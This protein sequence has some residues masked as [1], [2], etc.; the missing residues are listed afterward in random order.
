ME[1]VGAESAP[2]DFGTSGDDMPEWKDIDSTLGV[3]KPWSMVDVPDLFLTNL[4]HDVD[5]TFTDDSL[6]DFSSTMNN[7]GSETESNS[8]AF[9]D[10]MM[11]Q[12]SPESL[13]NTPPLVQHGSEGGVDSAMTSPP[14]FPMDGQDMTPLTNQQ[15]ASIFGFSP[16][17]SWNQEP[18]QGISPTSV[19]QSPPMPVHKPVIPIR[20]TSSLPD[21][22]LS[23]SQVPSGTPT[24]ESILAPLHMQ[25]GSN[26]NA[27]TALNRLRAVTHEC[28]KK[29]QA[30]K[31]RQVKSSSPATTPQA[32]TSS[33]MPADASDMWTRKNAHNAIER[34]YRSNINDRIAGL[35]DVVPALREMQSRGPRRKRRRG[36]AEEVELVDGI[37]AATKLSK[38]TILSKATEYIC[39]L[40]S[41]EVRLSREVA[42]LHMLLRSLEGGDE[43][44]SQWNAEMERLHA[45]YPP[46]DAVYPDGPTVPLSPSEDAE[47]GDLVDESD[48]ADDSESVSSGGEPMR[49]KA[50]RYMLG[51]FLIPSLLGRAD[52]GTEAPGVV[53]QTHVM[54]VCHQLWKRSLGSSDAAHPYDHIPFYDLVWEFLRGCTLLGLVVVVLL[55][56][57]AHIRQWSRRLSLKQSSRLQFVA[58]AEALLRTPAEQAQAAE[59]V[60]RGHAKRMYAQLGELLHVPRTYMALTWGTAYACLCLLATVIPGVTAWIRYASVDPTVS[61]LHRRAHMR[62]AELEVTLGGDIQPDLAQRL[63]TLVMVQYAAR[64]YGAALDETLLLAL[65]YCDL[66]QHTRLPFLMRHGAYLWRTTGA[67]LVDAPNSDEASQR[68][69]AE[70]LSV[71][72]PQALDYARTTTTE[73]SVIISPLANMLEALRHEALLSYWT[74]MI[75]SMMR[76]AS[77]AEKQWSPNVLDVIKDSASLK[78]IQQQLRTLSRDGASSAAFTEQMLVAHGMLD[79]AAGRLT[80]AQMHAR[81]LKQHQP[82]S[83]AAQQFLALWKDTPLV[84]GVPNGPVDMLASVVIGWFVL[85]RKQHLHGDKQEVSD[86]VAVC[87]STLQALASQCLWTFVSPPEKGGH[88]HFQPKQAPCLVHA[89][90]LL[91]DQLNP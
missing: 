41:R 78:D 49:T 61:L 74:T 29:K 64:V 83:L 85:L 38:A 72:V 84:A 13:S 35:R 68:M 3:P 40:K 59:P 14:D 39:Y 57:G 71:P 26:S 27:M 8:D 53:P 47:E 62:R 37:R 7:S 48:D 46:M 51:A 12:S 67:R 1:E 15:L 87:T 4:I 55:S 23:D 91:L 5:H 79:L 75:T 90:D 82:T 28:E 19:Q 45:M 89:L 2:V 17:S 76:T 18:T 60:D 86:Q 21:S 50:A 32:S 31:Q 6:T 43:L 33:S 73:T 42:G 52:W 88:V 25:P 56:I 80:R 58:G 24:Q 16:T 36:K 10:F 63:Y 54:G 77:L 65:I 69:L 11:R 44:M 81:S 70:L 20:P 34:R 30:N 66:A 9:K 22:Q